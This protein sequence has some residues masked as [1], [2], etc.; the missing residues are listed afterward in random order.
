MKCKEGWLRIPDLVP[1]FW[2]LFLTYFTSFMNEKEG[3]RGRKIRYPHQ[4]S[5][6]TIPYPQP[7]RQPCSQVCLCQPRIWT[8]VSHIPP[9]S[10]TTTWGLQ[11]SPTVFC[12]RDTMN[13]EEEYNADL[14]ESR[15]SPLQGDNTLW[16]SALCQVYL[17]KVMEVYKTW[18]ALW[19]WKHSYRWWYIHQEC[20][21]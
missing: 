14:E 2:G 19:K 7:P 9:V 5:N 21:C 10:H 11:M 16:C 17:A 1:E 15:W 8:W 3:G 18:Q 6:H 4:V 12:L 20:Y 13:H